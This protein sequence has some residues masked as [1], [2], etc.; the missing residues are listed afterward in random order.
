MNI[1]FNHDADWLAIHI[2]T[3]HDVV[4]V[5]VDHPDRSLGCYNAVGA[6]PF[7]A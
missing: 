5:V 6:K 2:L 7:T 4:H 3:R 1:V